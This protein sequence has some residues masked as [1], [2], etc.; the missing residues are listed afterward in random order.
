LADSAP[1]DQPKADS[2]PPVQVTVSAVTVVKALLLALLIFLAVVAADA[3]LGI[4]LALIFALGLDPVVGKLTS[5]RFAG[6]PATS[7]A[8]SRTSRTRRGSRSWRTTPT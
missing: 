1:T 7:R 2:A 4:L 5:T 6:S 8:T 3:L